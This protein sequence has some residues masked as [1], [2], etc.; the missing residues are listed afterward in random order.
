MTV[1]TL[2]ERDALVEEVELYRKWIRRASEVCAAAARGDLE[3]RVLHIDVEGDLGDMLRNLNLAFDIADAFVREAGASLQ[4]ATEEKFYRRVLTRGL[5]GTY[6]NAAGLINEASSHLAR[7]T[8]EVAAARA[9]QARLANELA[10]IAAA[11]ASAATQ[12]RASAD[13]LA[14]TSEEASRRTR[15]ALRA[16]SLVS[17][18]MGSISA[19]AERIAST[20]EE[21]EQKTR[22]ASEVSDHISAETG[23]VIG[24]FRGLERASVEISKVNAVTQRVASQTR[25]LALNATIEA[26]RA[27]ELGKGFAVVAQEVKDLANQTAEATGGIRERISSIQESTE[28]SGSAIR[29]IAE[30]IGRMTAISHTVGDAVGSQR[31]ATSEINHDLQEVTTGAREVTE[32]VTAVD[33]E[34]GRTL[35]AANMLVQAANELSRLAETLNEASSGLL[36]ELAHD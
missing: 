4:H 16:S 30:T 6:R 35:D 23:N 29:D 7:K 34:A 20:T 31:S 19:A 28:H 13:E 32:S 27:G 8:A 12:T 21:I 14:R 17:E 22:E 1:A 3:E 36:R 9:A 11:V 5:P 2:P 24:R 26:A 18:R 10:E 25:L 15:D 33:A